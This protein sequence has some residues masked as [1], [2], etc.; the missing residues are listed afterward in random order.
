MS[1]GAQFRRSACARRAPRGGV[2]IN[3]I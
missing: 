2:R 1:V 3:T